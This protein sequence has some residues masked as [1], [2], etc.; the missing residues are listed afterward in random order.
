[1]M[2]SMKKISLCPDYK[3]SDSD[4]FAP[5]LKENNPKTSTKHKKLICNW[6]GGRK[7]LIHHKM[8]KV[9]VK[10]GIIG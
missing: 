8:L 5:L 6:T 4:D 3:R 9:Y 7:I 1:M 10:H 2:K